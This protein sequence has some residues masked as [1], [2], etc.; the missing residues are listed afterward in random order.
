[1]NIYV[2]YQRDENSVCCICFL[3]GNEDVNYCW[4]Y[5]QTKLC[6]M[7]SKP[8]PHLKIL[9]GRELFYYHFS[10]YCHVWFWYLLQLLI[11]IILNQI[12]ILNKPVFPFYMI[13]RLFY[14]VLLNTAI[15][16]LNPFKGNSS[17]VAW[18]HHVM[19]INIAVLLAALYDD[20]LACGHPR[21]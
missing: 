12:L 4:F 14:F 5:Y 17:R 3:Y 1:M 9:R 15:S 21:V 16:F 6:C 11:M 8:R 10:L 20:Q 13:S 2:L 18:R 19:G 7:M